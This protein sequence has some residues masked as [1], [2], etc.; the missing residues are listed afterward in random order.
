MEELGE[1][2]LGEWQGLTIQ[3]LDQRDDWKRFNTFRSGTPAPGGELMLETQA[4]M[5]RQLLQLRQKHPTGTVAVVSHGDPLR[6]V[7]AFFLGIPL[8]FV[9]RFEISPAS[10]SVVQLHE[11]GARVLCINHTGELP[12]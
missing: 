6:A 9:L 11:W 4:R 5:V 2:R 1:I 8:D 7:L 3:E 12:V 10:V